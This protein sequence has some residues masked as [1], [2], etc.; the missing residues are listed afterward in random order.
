MLPEWPSETFPQLVNHCWCLSSEYDPTRACPGLSF[1]A[2]HPAPSP[3]ASHIPWTQQNPCPFMPLDCTPSPP[4]P[5][6][7]S[8]RSLGSSPLHLLSP[9]VP[10]H[11]TR[12]AQAIR[13]LMHLL[14][15][16]LCFTRLSSL[17]A[18]PASDPH[19]LPRTQGGSRA[20]AINTHKP[21]NEREKSQESTQ[22]YFAQMP[23]KVS[24][25]PLS[26]CL[27]IG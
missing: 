22:L 8:R 14:P 25:L 2:L 1:L 3:Q 11:A 6:N 23:F 7:V 4:P 19:P 17:R 18:E 5:C 26:A 16:P 24:D 21:M 12:T 20:Q 27:V 9:H 15:S 13:S 10:G